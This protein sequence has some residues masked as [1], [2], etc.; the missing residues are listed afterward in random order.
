M[1]EPTKTWILAIFEGGTTFYGSKDLIEWERLSNIRFGY[2]CPDVFE[3]PLDGDKSN[4]KWIL[5]DANGSYLVGQ[6]DGK[7]FAKE[8]EML[9]MDA[10]RDFYAAQTFFRPN[11]PSDALVQIAWNDRWNGGVGEKGWERNATFPVVLGLVTYDG[12]MRVTRQPI[13]GIRELYQ[14]EPKTL[15]KATLTEGENLLKDI[16]SKTFNMTVVF[17]LKDTKATSIDFQIAQVKFSYD[18]VNA[19]M[20]VGLPKGKPKDLSLKPDEN[21]VLEIRMLV[22]WAQLEIFSAGGVFSA[23]YQL[24]FTPDDSTIGLSATGGEVKLVSLVFNEVD[25]IWPESNGE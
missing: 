4:M 6:F 10:G 2:E 5:Q 19:Q 8:Q 7:Q 14:G 24:G 20:C 11:F 25:S 1:Y 16:K 15:R 22:D 17:D 21:G 13:K 9:V 23:S 18:I 12:K 3:L